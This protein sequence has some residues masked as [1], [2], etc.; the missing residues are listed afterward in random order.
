[1]I[2]TTPGTFQR[3]RQSLFRCAT[4]CVDTQGGHFEHFL[5]TSGSHNLETML[6]EAYVH[7]QFIL[8]CVDSASVGLTVHFLFTLYSRNIQCK[9]PNPTT[10]VP[11]SQQYHQLFVK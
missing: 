3:V 10:S 9:F 11:H 5:L 4:C 6:Q 7:K 2:H 1:M 8:D